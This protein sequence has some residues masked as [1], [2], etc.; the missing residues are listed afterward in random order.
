MLGSTASFHYSAFSFL[1]VFPLWFSCKC[2]NMLLLK[3]EENGF[4]SFEAHVT[5]EIRVPLESRHQ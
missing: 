3:S 5:S 1:F 2:L 4:I